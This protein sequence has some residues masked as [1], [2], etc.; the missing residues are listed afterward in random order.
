MS[1]P[2]INDTFA[3]GKAESTGY[4]NDAQNS[5]VNAQNKE[6]DYESLLADY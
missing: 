1:R 3:Q 5:Y 4:Y 2:Q 6:K